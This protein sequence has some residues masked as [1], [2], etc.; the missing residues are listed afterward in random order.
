MVESGEVMSVG[1]FE[2]VAELLGFEMGLEAGGVFCWE[3]GAELVELEAGGVFCWE[4][5]AKLAEEGLLLAIVW[6]LAILGSDTMKMQVTNW[7][8]CLTKTSV[9]WYYL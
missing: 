9:A 8:G 3:E 5:E 7:F 4:K 1:G 6:A 2:D